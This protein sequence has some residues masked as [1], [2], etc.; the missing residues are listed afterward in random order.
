MAELRQ[1]TE[2]EGVSLKTFVHD[3]TIHSLHE[4]RVQTSAMRT[5]SAL[6]EVNQKLADL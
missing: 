1:V 4:R 5:I 6:S 3:A 2:S